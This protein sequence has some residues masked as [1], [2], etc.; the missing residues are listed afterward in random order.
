MNVLALDHVHIYA[1][2]PDATLDFYIDVLGAEELGSIPAGGGRRNHFVILGG[3]I[4]AVSAFPEG[5]EP[6]PAAE[7]GDGALRTGFGIAHLGINVDDIDGYVARLERHGVDVHQHEGGSGPRQSGVLRYIYFTAPD[8]V[9]IELTQYELPAK[10]RPAVK[11]LGL[12][13]R[14]IHQ[15][16]KTVTKTLLQLA[17]TG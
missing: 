1:S 3:Q 14:T 6:A 9:V 5:L 2:D 7:V 10:F 11:L 16:K 4:L 15:T 13:N 8:G 12:M 17:P